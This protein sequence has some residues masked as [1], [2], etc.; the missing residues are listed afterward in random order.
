MQTHPAF[1]QIRK[2]RQSVQKMRSSLQIILS[3]ILP[4]MFLL[5]SA[6]EKRSIS[7][8]SEQRWQIGIFEPETTV[9]AEGSA[10]AFKVNSEV[11]SER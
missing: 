11:E 4:L 5:A 9:S 2:L 8:K 7:V 6:N 1:C 10:V 3:L